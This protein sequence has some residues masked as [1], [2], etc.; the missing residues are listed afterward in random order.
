M[1][2][3][4]V[5]YVDGGKVVATTFPGALD[6]ILNQLKLGY[7]TEDTVDAYFVEDVE[8]RQEYVD[9]SYVMNLGYIAEILNE[10]KEGRGHLHRQE[11]RQLLQH[12]R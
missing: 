12:R 3:A 6:D 1:E 7:Q 5:L 10:T 2:Y 4:Y 8:I 9:S 11:G